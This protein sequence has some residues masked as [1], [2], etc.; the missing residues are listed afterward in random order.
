MARGLCSN[1]KQPVYFGFDKAL[2][3]EVVQDTISEL[4]KSGFTVVG[5][6]SDLGPSNNGVWS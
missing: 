5:V 2:T 3:K 4:Y 6:T 1:W